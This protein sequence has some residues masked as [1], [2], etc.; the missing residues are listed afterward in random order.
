MSFITINV[1]PNSVKSRLQR[2]IDYFEGAGLTK[3]LGDVG[4][5]QLDEHLQRFDYYKTDYKNKPLMGLMDSYYKWKV[6]FTGIPSQN[7]GIL[8]GK[9]R[10]MTFSRVEGNKMYIENFVKND[11][12]RPYARHFQRQRPIFGFS[13]QG[14]KKAKAI[15]VEALRKLT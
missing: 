5:D 3:T 1:N 6:R 11:K 2:F 10:A 7:I 15:C 9:M 13:P 8:T 14:M 12:G 4:D